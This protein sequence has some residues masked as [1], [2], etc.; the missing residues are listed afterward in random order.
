MESLILRCAVEQ[1]ADWHPHLFLEPHIVACIAV[2]S[3]YTASPSVLEVECI[4][5]ESAWL[6][7][8]DRFIL[9][10]SW[11][12]QQAK[13]AE[14]L[15]L[16]MQSNSLVELAAIALATI[17]TSQV[18]N[19]GQLDVTNYGERAD[20][21]SLD[22]PA[23]LEISGTESP[24]EFERRHRTKVTQALENPLGLDAYVVVCGFAEDG[25]RVRFS[26]HRQHSDDGA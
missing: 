26:Y 18:V 7:G 22:V 5:I 8:A 6:D 2:L 1:I 14:R 12:E 11:S 15:R 4:D 21:R 25:H 9:E 20:Y 19:L 17:L 24:V 3:Q 16:T 13:N 23:V 10:L